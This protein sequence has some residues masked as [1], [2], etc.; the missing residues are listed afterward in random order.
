MASSTGTEYD[1]LKENLIEVSHRAYHAQLQMG[2]GGNL[3]IR[4]PGKDL[5]IIKPSGKGFMEL[6]MDNLLVV[7]LNCEVVSG[8]GKPSRDSMTHAGIYKLRPEIQGIL[9]VH[10]T[11]ALTFAMDECE[12]PLVTEE[13]IDK[14]KSIPIVPCVP[15]RLAQN[16]QEVAA[17][18]ADSSVKVA[19]LAKHG[20]IA[21]GRSLSE[22]AEFC[23]L[24]NECAKLAYLRRLAKLAN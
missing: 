6:N 5:F 23:E 18:F 14:I 20:I 11:W 4:I 10:A 13:S 24:T 15:G 17:K 9:H 8:Q 12:I 3:S 21:A 1:V 16:H 22:A 2:S 7:N 19:M